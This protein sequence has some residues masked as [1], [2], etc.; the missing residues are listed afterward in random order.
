MTVLTVVTIERLSLHHYIS[1]RYPQAPG[2]SNLAGH[3][4]GRG[5]VESQWTEPGRPGLRRLRSNFE[6]ASET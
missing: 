1:S 4:D 6:L 2:P 5:R 3:R